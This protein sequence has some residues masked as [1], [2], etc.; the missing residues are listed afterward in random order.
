MWAGGGFPAQPWLLAG[1]GIMVLVVAPGIQ[2]TADN[3]VYNGKLKLKHTNNSV[4]TF[5]FHFF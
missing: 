4:L 2:G 5:K 3:V 1:L